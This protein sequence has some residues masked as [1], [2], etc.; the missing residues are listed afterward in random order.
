MYFVS[1]TRLQRTSK[2]HS[3][4]VSDPQIAVIIAAADF[5]W[6][7][8]RCVLALGKSPTSELRNIK[9]KKC[10]GLD[11]YKDLWR[12]EVFPR[13]GKRLPEVISQWQNFKKIGFGL[14]NKLVHGVG[15]SGNPYAADAAQLILD[16]SEEL[17][18]FAVQHGEPIFARRIVRYKAR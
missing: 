18:S 15:T 11:D 6:S 4:I 5:E 12:D 2:I 14:R 13:Y 16:A 7:Y 10:R 8:C 3:F 9:I 17:N 1:D